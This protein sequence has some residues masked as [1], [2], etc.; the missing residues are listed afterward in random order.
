MNP[1]QTLKSGYEVGARRIAEAII[2]KATA[3]SASDKD[4]T[5][6]ETAMI[7]LAKAEK[8]AGS[9]DHATGEAMI[10]ERV[11]A[12]I[13]EMTRHGASDEEIHASVMQSVARSQALEQQLTAKLDHEAANAWKEAFEHLAR[14]IDAGEPGLVR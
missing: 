6:A 1:D 10:A 3:P 7:I 13:V 4:R 11:E 5:D 14:M 12:Q 2:A 9:A 8:R